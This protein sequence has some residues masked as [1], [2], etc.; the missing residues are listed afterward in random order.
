YERSFAEWLKDGKCW[1]V[2]N[3]EYVLADFLY[4]E[5]ADNIL[6]AMLR[7]MNSGYTPILAHVERY[8]KLHR[9]LR[10]IDRLK[11]W[12]VV[13][14]LD[15]QSVLG[16]LG[17]FSKARSRRILSAGLADF[18]ASDAHDLTRRPPQLSRCCDFISRRYGEE[19][20]RILFW[21][22]PIRILEGKAV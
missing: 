11:S 17:Y 21:D 19:Y 12:G 22:N 4:P 10:E 2:N 7:I 9:D 15:A 3:T 20:A 1:T 6:D 16:N 5:P 18:V 8:E 14:Q 13:I